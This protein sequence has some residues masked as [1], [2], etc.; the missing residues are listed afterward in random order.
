MGDNTIVLLNKTDIALP[1]ALPALVHG[2]KPIF[3]S[4]KTGSGME[5]LLQALSSYV[6]VGASAE[7]SFITRSRHRHHLSAALEHL[8]RYGSLKEA[9]LELQCEELRRASAEIGRITGLIAADEVLGEI[10]GRF[11][12]GK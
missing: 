11:C 7:S 2:H 10:F 12:I 5:T 1:A 8:K 9:G 6:A 3:F 4:A